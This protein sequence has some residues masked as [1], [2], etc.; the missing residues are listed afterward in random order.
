MTRRVARLD[1]HIS[2]RTLAQHLRRWHTRGPLFDASE[3]A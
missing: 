2:P 3:V 1:S